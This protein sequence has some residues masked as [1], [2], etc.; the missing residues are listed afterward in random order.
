MERRRRRRLVRRRRTGAGPVQSK[1]KML[2]E[3]VPGCAD[4]DVE[5]LLARTADYITLL[6]L[7]ASLLE[8]LQTSPVWNLPG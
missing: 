6:E 7:H 1:L 4:Q 5:T 2:E 3:L 8:S